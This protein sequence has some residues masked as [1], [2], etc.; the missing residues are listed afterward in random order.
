MLFYCHEKQHELLSGILHLFVFSLIH[1]YINHVNNKFYFNEN[2]KQTD[3]QSNPRDINSE[4]HIN[5]KKLKP[6]VLLRHV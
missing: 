4:C 1:K 6:L 5:A 2:E 3:V